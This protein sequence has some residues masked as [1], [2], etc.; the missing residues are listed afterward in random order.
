MGAFI[1]QL[2]NGLTISAKLEKIGKH[3]EIYFGRRTE[4]KTMRACFKALR[5]YVDVKLMKRE[6]VEILAAKAD[7]YRNTHLK[8]T[9]LREWRA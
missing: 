5:A 1:S 4:T 9:V 2:M 8:K 7:E 3:A 6:R